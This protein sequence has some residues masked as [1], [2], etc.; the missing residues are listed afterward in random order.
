MRASALRL[1]L[2]EK[3]RFLVRHQGHDEY[4]VRHKRANLQYAVLVDFFANLVVGTPW[5]VCAVVSSLSAFRDPGYRLSAIPGR[6]YMAA[7]QS[8]KSIHGG[9]AIREVDTR[10][11]ADAGMTTHGR[12]SEGICGHGTTVACIESHRNFDA[13]LTMSPNLSPPSCPCS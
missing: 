3:F 9:S 1:I 13:G 10:P 4:E 11:V 5:P 8:R 2:F 6:R 7:R 12:C